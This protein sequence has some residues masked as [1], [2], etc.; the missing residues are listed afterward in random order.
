MAMS[1]P[2]VLNFPA[3]TQNVSLARTV[4]AAMASRADLPIDQLEDLRLAVSEAVALLIAEAPAGAILECSFHLGFD[5]LQVVMSAPAMGPN[6][7]ATDTFSWT[8]L[9]ALLDDITASTGSGRLTLTLRMNRVASADL[10]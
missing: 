9:R 5:A 3:E 6:V 4:A 1:D 2:V 10:A 8:I 7:P